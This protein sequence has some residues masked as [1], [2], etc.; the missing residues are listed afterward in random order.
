M[1]EMK[2]KVMTALQSINCS[3]GTMEKHQRTESELE[4]SFIEVEKTTTDKDK[5]IY[6]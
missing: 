2:T 1:K 5:E 3:G 4:S 6:K